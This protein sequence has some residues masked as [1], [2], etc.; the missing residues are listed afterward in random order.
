L[1]ANQGSIGVG[2]AIIGEWERGCLQ[3][4]AARIVYAI[5][6]YASCVHLH[7]WSHR[8]T[9]SMYYRFPRRPGFSG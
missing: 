9:K 6:V 2:A 5:R 3:I 4:I 1:R 8:I 7:R